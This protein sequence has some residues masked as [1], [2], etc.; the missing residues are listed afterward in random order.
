MQQLEDNSSLKRAV[1]VAIAD[2]VSVAE[3]LDRG[4]MDLKL[5]I[6]FTELTRKATDNGSN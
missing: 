5:R 2:G 4:A 1:K 3:V 6:A